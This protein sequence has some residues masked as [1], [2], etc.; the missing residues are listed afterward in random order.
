MV[1]LDFALN[2]AMQLPA[3]QKEMLVEIL[4]KRRIEERRKEIAQ[5]A[6]EAREAFHRGELK[7]ET[8]EEALERLH[9]SLDS[10]EDE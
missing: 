5:N 7:E 4:Q 3:E 8:L 1:T 2:T 9:A 10:A 6:K